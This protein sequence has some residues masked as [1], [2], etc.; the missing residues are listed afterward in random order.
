M[1][2]DHISHSSIDLFLKC[3]KRWKTEY[4]DKINSSSPAMAR[5]I[6]LHEGANEI[7]RLIIADKESLAPE[8]VDVIVDKVARKYKIMQS[9]DKFAELKSLLHAFALKQFENRR[10]IIES[11][12]KFEFEVSAGKLFTGR[13]DEIAVDDADNIIITDYKS[14]TL[15][16][17]RAEIKADTQLN[18]YAYA[19]CLSF[20]SAKRANIYIAQQYL[21]TG[22]RTELVLFEKERIETVESWLKLMYE[23]MEA[24]TEYESSPEAEHCFS[25]PRKCEAYKDWCEKDLLGYDLTDIDSMINGYNILKAKK[26]QIEAQYK[27]NVEGLKVSLA[28]MPDRTFEHNGTKYKLVP[29][30]RTMPAQEL[31]IDKFDQIVVVNDK[32]KKRMQNENKN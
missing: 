12:F 6:A 4:I 24:E 29:K 1:T 10:R 14:T 2:L 25:C 28:Y 17:D 30:E 13:I 23:E 7:N 19:V 31:R 26:S 3:R 27:Q 9:L 16:R 11:E 5:G 15:M 18:L 22:I 20:A 21:D 8:D 32:I